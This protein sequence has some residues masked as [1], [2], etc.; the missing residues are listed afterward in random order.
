MLVEAVLL[1]WDL[2][3]YGKNPTKFFKYQK[4]D[5]ME[6]CHTRDRREHVSS[7]RCKID[8]ESS[9]L[10]GLDITD[11]PSVAGIRACSSLSDSSS[12]NK[13]YQVEIQCVAC[14]RSGNLV[15]STTLDCTDATLKYTTGFKRSSLKVLLEFKS[16]SF[17]KYQVC[18]VF[19][20]Q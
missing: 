11:K 16:E 10:L 19:V 2:F 12:A 14:V 17:F 20:F 1:P 6:L 13:Q 9:R 4:K 18:Y 3:L 15:T 5:P 7:K 8:P